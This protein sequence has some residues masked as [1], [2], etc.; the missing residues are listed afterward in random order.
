MR[1]VASTGGSVSRCC[2]GRFCFMDFSSATS[3]TRSATHATGFATTA[4]PVRPQSSRTNDLRNSGSGIMEEKSPC[5]LCFRDRP[6]PRAALPGRAGDH[7]RA[8][9]GH[10]AATSTVGR[11]G[12]GGDR[13]SGAAQRVPGELHPQR[14][15][16]DQ[17]EM[18]AE[19][20]PE[21]ESRRVRRARMSGGQAR[22]PAGP[23]PAG[24]PR[25]GG[26]RAAV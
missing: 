10:P 11:D 24:L 18:A 13:R 14:R 9:A 3:G 21:W 25:G 22:S 8:E 1:R 6:P 19:T 23:S 4:G 17:S 12:L 2:A 16:L 7:H 20:A 15:A 5:L 26:G